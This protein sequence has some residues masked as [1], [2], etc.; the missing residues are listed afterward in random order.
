MPHRSRIENLRTHPTFLGRGVACFFARAT[1]GNVERFK[2]IVEQVAESVARGEHVSVHGLRRGAFRDLAVLGE[3]VK[4]PRT[5]VV[6]V[7]VSTTEARFVAPVRGED[8]FAYLYKHVAAVQAFYPFDGDLA[9]HVVTAEYP[10]DFKDLAA[11]RHD[12][13]MKVFPLVAK[14]E[15]FGVSS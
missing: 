15:D 1:E 5:G 7:P 11:H 6:T 2:L 13:V 12:D 8:E 9:F 14:K 4:L 3:E 10:A